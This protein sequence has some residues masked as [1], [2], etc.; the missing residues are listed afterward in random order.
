MYINRGKFWRCFR[1]EVGLEILWRKYVQ[2][3]GSW[4]EKQ[5]FQEI[6]AV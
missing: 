5:A 2:V 6:G 1:H 3:E 4:R